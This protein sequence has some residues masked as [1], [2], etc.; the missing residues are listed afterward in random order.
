MNPH[1]RLHIDSLLAMATERFVERLMHRSGSA[2]AA[3]ERLAQSGDTA[4]SFVEMFFVDTLLNTTA[5]ACAVLEAYESESLPNPAVA[6]GEASATVGRAVERLAR[7]VFA[8]VLVVK[9]EEALDFAASR[10]PLS[11]SAQPSHTSGH[12]P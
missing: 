7:Q 11:A 5:G 12:H 1:E 6:I 2:R 10:E 8:R 4:A 9:T 3:R